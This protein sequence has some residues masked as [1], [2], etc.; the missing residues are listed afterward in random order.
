MRIK[1][2]GLIPLSLYPFIPYKEKK[3]KRDR[4]LFF[5]EDEDSATFQRKCSQMVGSGNSLSLCR[6]REKIK[7]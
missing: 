7:R 1:K 3:K 6:Q 4:I 2:R 5:C